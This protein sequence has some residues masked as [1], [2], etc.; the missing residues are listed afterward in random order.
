MRGEDRE[1]K[2]Y[3]LLHKK[4]KGI[5]K[6]ILLVNIKFTKKGRSKRRTKKGGGENDVGV[7]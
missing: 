6:D 3:I 5:K 2:Y 7:V 4:K 1:K